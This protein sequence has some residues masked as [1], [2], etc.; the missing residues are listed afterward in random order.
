MIHARAPLVTIGALVVLLVA[1]PALSAAAQEQ[2]DGGVIPVW[3]HGRIVDTTTIADASAR[4]LLVLDLGEAWVPFVLSGTEARPH[5]YEPVFRRIAQGDFPDTLEGYRARLDR[6]HELYGIPPTLSRLRERFFEVALSSCRPRIDLAA[7]GEFAGSHLDEDEASPL[8][9]EA[10][11]GL[12][13]PI[14]QL[15]RRQGVTEP[16]NL[17]VTQLSPR[18]RRLLEMYDRAAMWRRALGAIRYRLAC[19]GHLRGRIPTGPELDRRTRAAIAELERAHRIYARGSLSGATLRALQTDPL[20]LAHDDVIRVLTERALLALGVVEDGST[21]F[22]EEGE[23]RT[24][25][26]SRGEAE[27]MANLELEMSDRIV[28]AFGL[29]TPEDTSDWLWRVGDLASTPHLRVAID[30]VPLPEYYSDV[31]D[32]FVRIDRG[33][34]WYDFPFDEEGRP[35][36]QPVER[37]PTLTVYV[38]HLGQEIPLARYKTTI[39]SWRLS[40][41]GG[42]EMWTYKE[43][44]V[45]TRVLAHI[46]S[47]PVWLPPRDTPSSDLVTE[48]RRTDDGALVTEVNRNLV[49]PG[50]ASAYGL[51]AG[52]HRR[53]ER[54]RDGGMAL[55]ADEGIRTH[56]SVDYT[57]IWRRASHGCHR[58]QNHLA[59]RLYTFVL[60]HREFRRLGHRRVDYQVPVEVEGLQDEVRIERTGYIFALR[61]PVE[62]EVLPGRIRG[63]ARTPIREAIPRQ[64]SGAPLAPTQ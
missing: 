14:H 7:I 2:E 53:F 37:M 16:A 5:V 4:G 51:I 29:H 6:Y 61:R 59:L 47:A 40:M 30:S 45:G 21:L 64:G 49:G 1:A 60:R 35:I 43:S 13:G 26:S 62:V 33:D 56:G 46:V 55:G 57:S 58:L 11:V 36:P 31:M 41:V 34:V 10:D 3:R 52:Y 63:R 9:A 19:E 48:I 25:R 24:Y 27:P 44:P 39:G 32:I 23:L 15:L 54:R 50:Y 22:A 17:D 42:E 18:Q 8:I 20:Q 12:V 38:R 28:R